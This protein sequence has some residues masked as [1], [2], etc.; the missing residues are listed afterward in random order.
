MRRLATARS[1]TVA[2]PPPPP[3][4]R[5]RAAAA[6]AEEHRCRSYPFR[7]L[8]VPNVYCRDSELRDNDRRF[9]ANP[10]GEKK[11]MDVDD[12]PVDSA[13]RRNIDHAIDRDRMTGTLDDER[14]GAHYSFCE[15]DHKNWE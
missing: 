5:V 7:L 6:I 2:P 4:P 14:D 8:H 15:N 3:P 11:T 9:G 12:A 10:S 1:V 13:D